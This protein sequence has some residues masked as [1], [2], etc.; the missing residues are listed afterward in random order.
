MY[1]TSHDSHHSHCHLFDARLLCIHYL[2][3]TLVSIIYFSL[4]KIKLMLRELSDKTYM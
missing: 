4:G 1:D 3:I 2:I